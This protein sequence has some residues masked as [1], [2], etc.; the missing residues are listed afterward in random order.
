MQPI[1]KYASIPKK[2]PAD[3]AAGGVKV[4]TGEI[5]ARKAC[6]PGASS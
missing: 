5:D 1:L 6:P 4:V 3:E 2:S